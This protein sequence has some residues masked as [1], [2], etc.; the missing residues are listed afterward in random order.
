M[1]NF[2]LYLSLVFLWLIF[3]LNTQITIT[4]SYTNFEAINQEFIKK[5]FIQTNFKI[6]G[7]FIIEGNS[8]SKLQKKNCRS[9]TEYGPVKHIG[10]Y[11][12]YISVEMDENIYLI[13]R[14]NKIIHWDM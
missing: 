1:F 2:K 8:T 10:D 13:K 6:K 4:I 7:N 9:E 12:D 11:G 14:K 5:G 3:K